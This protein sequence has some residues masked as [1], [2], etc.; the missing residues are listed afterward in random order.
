MRKKIIM[1]KNKG[2]GLCNW[3]HC[4]ICNP[5]PLKNKRKLRSCGCFKCSEIK[6]QL[7]NKNYDNNKTIKRNEA[8]HNF[9]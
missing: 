1:N 2:G 4:E 6:K 7:N 8:R 3:L 5:N 9:C